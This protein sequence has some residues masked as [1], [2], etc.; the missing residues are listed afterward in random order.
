MRSGQG[1]IGRDRSEVPCLKARAAL[2]FLAVI[3]GWSFTNIVRTNNMIE[4]P[5]FIIEAVGERSSIVALHDFLATALQP[6]PPNEVANWEGVLDLSRL[7]P[8][9]AW[10]RNPSMSASENGGNWC[11]LHL[12]AS[13][14]WTSS[15]GNEKSFGDVAAH[16]GIVEE[17]A[18]KYGPRPERSRPTLRI[19]GRGLESSVFVRHLSIRFPELRFACRIVIDSQGYRDWEVENGQVRLIAKGVFGDGVLMKSVLDDRNEWAEEI[20]DHDQYG[21]NAGREFGD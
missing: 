8:I 7:F 3:A 12:K 2:P 15:A 14:E 1:M 13:P 5:F 21:E 9:H 16:L 6:T 10:V 19:A 11:H 20:E 17:M 18:T 4:L